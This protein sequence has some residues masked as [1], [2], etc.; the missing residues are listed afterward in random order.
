MKSGLVVAPAERAVSTLPNFR[1]AR[2]SDRS[3]AE[4]F[5]LQNNRRSEYVFAAV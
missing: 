1:G 4:F 5:A 3:H 2:Q